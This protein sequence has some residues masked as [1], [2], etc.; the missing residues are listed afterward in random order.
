M[1]VR[2]RVRVRVRAN[3]NPNPNPNQAQLSSTRG[4]S[5]AL[6]VHALRHEPRQLYVGHTMNL[7]REAC[8]TAS[9]LTLTRAG[10]QP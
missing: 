10:P 2:V 4:G 3:P 6:L 8:F 9:T 7:M 1:R 5:T